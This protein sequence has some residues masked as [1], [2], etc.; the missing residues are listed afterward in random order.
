MEVFGFENKLKGEQRFAIHSM[1]IE[2][3]SCS[4]HVHLAS[5]PMVRH[6]LRIVLQIITFEI[7]YCARKLST[8]QW[9]LS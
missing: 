2:F 4:C 7:N 5:L 9:C 8:F 6:M 3:F 1:A